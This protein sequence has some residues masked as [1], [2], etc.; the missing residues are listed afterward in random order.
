MKVSVIITT[1]RRPQVLRRAITSVL[2]QTWN[3]I[4]L[5]VVDDNGSG[6]LMQQETERIVSEFAGVKYLP[7]GHNLGQAASLNNGI[8]EASG[9]LIAFLDDDDEF[10]PDKI[11]KQVSRLLQTD[12][13]GC[14]CNYQRLIGTRVYYSSANQMGKDEGDLAREMLL[15]NNEICGGSTLLLRRRALNE[16]GGFDERFRRHVDWSFLVRFFRSHRLCLSEDVLVTIHMD[17]GLW[18]LDPRILFETKQLFLNTFR[19]D[20]ERHGPAARDIYFKHWSGIYFECLRA[21]LLGLALRSLF[22]SVK[23]GTLDLPRLA[24]ITASAIKHSL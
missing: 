3:N 16:T 22:H 2:Q 5:I 21:G 1:Y 23:Q 10:H 11:S 9:D 15:G 14:Y 13:D 19:G 17:E 24:R 18:K 12:S 4:E 20:I 6:S 7:N 8:N